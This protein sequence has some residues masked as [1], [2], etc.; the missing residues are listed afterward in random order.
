[1]IQNIAVLHGHDFDNQFSLW[2][3]VNLWDINLEERSRLD[4][5]ITSYNPKIIF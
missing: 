5:T 4:Y 2:E 1:M 3:I